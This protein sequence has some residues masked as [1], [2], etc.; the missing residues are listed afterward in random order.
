MY[1]LHVL[2][3][4]SVNPAGKSGLLLPPVGPSICGH[5]KVKMKVQLELLHDFNLDLSDCIMQEKEN[6]H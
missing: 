5:F 2:L 6:S 4:P 1:L 3:L